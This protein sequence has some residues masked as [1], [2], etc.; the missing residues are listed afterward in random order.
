MCTAKE[1]VEAVP[2]L[3]VFLVHQHVLPNK[4]RPERNLHSD[5]MSSIG[6]LMKIHR[7]HVASSHAF[8][9]NAPLI[10]LARI[11]ALQV[12]EH[13]HIAQRLHNHYANE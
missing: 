8:R 3:L 9:G 5:A 10:A 12:F 11:L 4:H 7:M 2:H 13:L 1:L 6:Y